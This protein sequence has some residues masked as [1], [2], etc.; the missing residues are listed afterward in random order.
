MKMR[1]VVWM[2][3][4]LALPAMQ[5]AAQ[6]QEK[7]A[8]VKVEKVY[9]KPAAFELQEESNRFVRLD[10]ALAASELEGVSVLE[11]SRKGY[12]L[13]DLPGGPV[14]VDKLSLRFNTALPNAYCGRLGGD[15]SVSFADDAA[16][17]AVRGAGEGCR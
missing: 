7:P 1:W 3:A 10:R 12:A 14:W 4:G 17:K 13:L 15:S 11:V 16:M 2:L 6:E 5:L 9:G 8:L